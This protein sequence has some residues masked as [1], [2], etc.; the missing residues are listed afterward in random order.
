MK[1][2]TFTQ[3]ADPSVHQLY[4]VISRRNRNKAQSWLIAEV[5]STWSDSR[6]G[7][8][9][10]AMPAAHDGWDALLSPALEWTRLSPEHQLKLDLKRVFK[11][12][13]F[14]CLA[15]TAV[16]VFCEKHV[17]GVGRRW[18]M[19]IFP[20]LDWCAPESLIIPWSMVR[21]H[22]PLLLFWVSVR[23]YTV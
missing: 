9:Q 2:Q 16:E 1:N 19:S 22:A 17:R 12:V 15:R 4:K 6:S 10:S 13:G 18:T 5:F 11:V 3:A 7:E 8:T 21:S 20:S 23:R 14:F